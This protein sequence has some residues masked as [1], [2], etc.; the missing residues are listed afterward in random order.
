MI[1]KLSDKDL[2]KCK[3]IASLRSGAKS[4][5]DSR[6]TRTS[7]NPEAYERHLLGVKCELALANLFTTS[8]D[9]TFNW[10]DKN[11]PDIYLPDKRSVQVKGKF[12]NT[13]D[14]S[15]Q[16][17]STDVNEFKADIGILCSE[18]NLTSEI[19]VLGWFDKQTFLDKSVIKTF[20]WGNKR[21]LDVEELC[22]VEDLLKQ[23][24]KKHY[25]L[26]KTKVEKIFEPLCLLLKEKDNI[27]F[28]KGS[29]TREDIEAL[30]S[31]LENKIR[32]V[33]LDYGGF[34]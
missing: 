34:P 33:R 7:A 18:G 14:K 4:Y 1:L 16:L 10:G 22:P 21:C 17:R 9:E 5:L 28:N 30:I 2:S 8:I 15:F 20:S 12:K 27:T 31:A 29:Y 32:R 25:V 26:S 23:L 19:E 6:E 13:K 11:Q 24:K 3:R